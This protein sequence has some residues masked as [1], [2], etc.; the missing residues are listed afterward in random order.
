MTVGIRALGWAVFAVAAA[1]FAGASHGAVLSRPTDPALSCRL[2]PAARPTFRPGSS[3]KSCRSSV[4]RSSSR[5][6]PAPAAPSRRALSPP[7]RPTAIRCW[8][9]IPA[10]SPSFRRYRRAPATIRPRISRRS[11]KF[12]RAIRSSSLHSVVAVQIRR[13]ACRLRQGQSR[14]AQLTRIPAPAA[15]RISPANCSNRCA[16][17]DILG[18]SYKSGG[19]SVT[20]VL[21]HQVDMTFESITILLPLIRDGK[22]RALA[23]TIARAHAARA[24]SADHDRG[25]RSRLR[26]DDLQRHRRAGRHAGADRRACSTPRSTKACRRRRS[27][28]PSPSSARSRIPARPKTSPP[29]SPRN[30][31]NGCRW[32]SPRNI[33][34]D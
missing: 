14:Q 24:R 19:E 6:A 31:A 30:T 28:T 7:P 33:N 4:S 10:C 5:T 13:R 1:G 34:I 18:V 29:S 26:G 12:P 21:G 20:A 25:R 3:R 2:R 9:A 8:S 23:I 15:C 17:V 16:G 32:R 11:P 22:L 27:R